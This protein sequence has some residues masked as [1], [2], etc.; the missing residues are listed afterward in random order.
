MQFKNHFLAAMALFA[1]SFSFAQQRIATY[2]EEKTEKYT[3]RIYGGGDPLNVREYTFNNGLKL[4][5]S[6]NKEQPR[7]YTMVAVKTGS[8]NDPADH[9]GL[10]HYLEHMLFKGTDQYGSL[11]W[12]KEKPL[13]DQIDKLY[14]EY[15]HSKDESV[16]KQIYHKIDSVSQL[17][18]KY[19]IANEFDKMCQAMGATGTNAFTSNEQTVYINDI[20]SNMMHKW[21]T[22][23]AERYRNPVLRLFHTELEA[24]YEEKNISMD[25]DGDKVWEKL[26]AGL[27][28]KHNYGQQTTI[29]TVEH[30]KN[31]SLEAIRKYYNTYYV[32]NNMAIV[33]AGDFDPDVAADAVAE[34]FSYMKKADFPAYTYEYEDPHASPRSIEITGPDAAYVTI[35]YRMPG[36]GSREARAARLIDLLLNNSSAGLIDL[37][38][39]KQQK[40]LSANSMVDVMN[41]YSV[42]VLTGKP[43]TGQ[44]LEEVRD[45]LI[46]QMKLI[47]NG[48]F[49]DSLLKAIIL[50]EEISKI[51]GYKENTSRA[52]MLLESFVNGSGYMK[53]FNELWEMSRVRKEE[54]MEIAREFLDRDRVEVFKREGVDTTIQKITKPEIS[55]VELN[56]DKQ[57]A[58]V[59]EWLK[60]ESESIAPVF[61]NFETDI[62]KAQ[63]GP[64]TLYYVAN[65]DN[66]LFTLEYRIEAGRFHDKKLPLAL[67]YLKFLGTA[68]MSADDVSKEMYALGC[69]FNAY[70]GEKRSYITLTGPEENF[71]KAVELLEKLLNQAVGNEEAFA[72]MIGNV[73]KQ[74]NDAKLN[75]RAIASMLSQY[76]RY[77]ADNPSKWQ[78]NPKELKALTSADLVSIIKNLS[79]TKHNITYYGNRS[80]AALQNTLKEK[81][82]MPAAFAALPA[83]KSFNERVNKEN[84]VFFVHYDQV[85][86]S[87][88]W[89]NTGEIYNPKDEPIISAF[90]QYFGGDMSSV[91]FQNIREAKALAY[92]TYAAYNVPSEAGKPF[93]TIAF[94][95]TQADKFHDA[96]KGMN[97]LLNDLPSDETAFGLAK[98]SLKNRVETERV[99]KESLVDYYFSLQDKGLNKDTRELLYAELPNI[100]MKDVRDFHKSRLAN[101]KHA[102]AVLASKDRV[103]TKDLEKYGKV[104]VLTLEDIFGY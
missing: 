74:R 22:L 35:G 17:A 34:H 32:P 75:N 21:I 54:I 68:D 82:K 78:L 16:R 31:P 3:V 86:A 91:V 90:N 39:V 23:E 4:I 6:T 49:D 98:E 20:P 66:R 48:K 94:I 14:E 71:D 92:S 104:T 7:I 87:I 96:L 65:T 51:R 53:S 19:A 63:I 69:S 52:F 37:N 43:K 84:E 64:A 77:G 46:E 73:E 45:L 67:N 38:L 93:T 102:Y 36:A 58:F 5:T 101:Q 12:S 61:P 100:T 10:A 41:D 28:E 1:C 97:E 13:L 11:D 62:Q 70:S 18:A 81:H 56:R 47:Q 44:T 79:N 8:K 9:T 25:R 80:F 15:N 55:P 60:E 85:Q 42:F 30:L 72:S 99:S 95:G 27:F 88:Y 40:V 103:K 89:W 76:A 83:P 29:G 50:N 33:M 59:S 26:Y 24:V 57:S 2:H